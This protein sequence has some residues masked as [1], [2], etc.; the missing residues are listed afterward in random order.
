MFAQR[1]DRLK[2]RMKRKF[3]AHFVC[4]LLFDIVSLAVLN[5]NFFCVPPCLW[6]GKT[7]FDNYASTSDSGDSIKTATTGSIG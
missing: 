2:W 1:N 4:R 6:I 3:K 7:A 5:S